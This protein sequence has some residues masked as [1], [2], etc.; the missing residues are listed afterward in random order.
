MTLIELI[1]YF[2]TNG[3]QDEFFKNNSLDTESE[4]VEIYM[5][6]PFSLENEIKFFEI[7]KSRGKVEY[8]I[9]NV[10]YFNLIDFYYFIDFIED[11]K[12]KKNENMTDIKLAEILLNYC[13]NDA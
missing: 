4:V 3:N 8:E 6:K 9:D 12:K 2:R 13:I 5:Q 1:H 10:K 7:E 11:S